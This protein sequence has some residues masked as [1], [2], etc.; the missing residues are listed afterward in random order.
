MDLFSNL[1]QQRHTSS[2]SSPQARPVR[3]AS[4]DFPWDNSFGSPLSHFDDPP[5]GEL[6]AP[7]PPV[8]FGASEY[9]NHPGEKLLNTSLTTLQDLTTFDT[10]SGSVTSSDFLSDDSP[11]STQP[12]S[13][14]SSQTT[15]GI[16]MCSRCSQIFEGTPVNQRRNLRRHMHSNHGV[17]PRLSCSVPQCSTTFAPGRYDNLSRHMTLQHGEVTARKRKSSETA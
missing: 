16:T 1:E 5:P 12:V 8:G 3:I 10:V 13:E 2:T 14:P 17:H 11:P 15:V 9:S 7:L 6:L 4:L